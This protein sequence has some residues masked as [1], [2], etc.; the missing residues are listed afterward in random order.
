MVTAQS[1]WT[2][3]CM[4]LQLGQ[5][6]IKHF[7]C[8]PF[9]SLFNTIVVLCFVCD[10]AKK[11]I[12][13]L[14]VWNK[15]NWL[16]FGSNISSCSSMFEHCC[17]SWSSFWRTYSALDCFTV[18]NKLT[19]V[20]CYHSDNH[21]YIDW[22]FNFSALTSLNHQT[23]HVWILIFMQKINPTCIQLIINC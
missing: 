10:N 5:I 4:G 3:N 17:Y 21:I 6:Y 13:C 20:V 9:N 12:H 22:L 16:C 19:I 14:L 23:T 2:W 11:K 18:D 7:M 15:S 1:T 8:S